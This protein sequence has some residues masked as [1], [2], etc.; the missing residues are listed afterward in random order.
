MRHD[1]PLEHFMTIRVRAAG[2]QSRRPV[3]AELWESLMMLAGFMQVGTAD[4]EGDM[5]K[6]SFSTRPAM[7]ESATLR[8]SVFSRV[9]LTSAR[10]MLWHVLPD[11]GMS[12]AGGGIG[13]PKRLPWAPVL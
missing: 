5:L 9:A 1:Q 8:G 6:M 11:D 12:N 10:V 13:V 2:V 7:S 3:A 4:C